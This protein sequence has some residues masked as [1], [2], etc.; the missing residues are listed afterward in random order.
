[1]D[2]GL[3]P[4]GLLAPLASG[5]FPLGLLV[6]LS[7]LVE[8]LSGLL[9]SGIAWRLVLIPPITGIIGYITN[10]V[11]IRL[12][13]Y[14]V[15]FW[16]VKIPGLSQL[17]QLLPTKIQQIPGVATGKIGWQGIVPSR[18]AKMGSLAVDNGINRI[19]TQREFYEA[20][21]EE[22]SEAIRDLITERMRNLPPEDY[23]MTLR[24][25]FQED[26]WLLIGIGAVLGFVAGWLQLLLVT[27]V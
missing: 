13:F 24:S 16:G 12:L 7:A 18:A 17:T 15:D 10:W 1:M 25:A 21:N 22:R 14:P 5:W 20:F 3:P 26:E 27:T 8:Q 4:A 19:A 11:G 9:P 2:V 23:V 6:V